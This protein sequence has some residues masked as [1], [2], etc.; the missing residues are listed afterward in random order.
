MPVAKAPAWKAEMPSPVYQSG[1]VASY[2]FSRVLPHSRS[3]P[4]MSAYGSSFS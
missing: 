2:Y 1:G 4:K 3:S